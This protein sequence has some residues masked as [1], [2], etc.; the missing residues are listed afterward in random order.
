MLEFTGKH[1][2]G[3]NCAIMYLDSTRVYITAGR[4]ISN[5]K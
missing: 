1:N 3:G 2:S 5:P 4:G